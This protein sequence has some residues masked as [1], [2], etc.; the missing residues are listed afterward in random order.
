MFVYSLLNTVL[1]NSQS[2]TFIL[3][4][5]TIVNMMIVQVMI[6][7]NNYAML[8]RIVITYALAVFATDF[9]SGVTSITISL[10][11]PVLVLKHT[12]TVPLFSG[13]T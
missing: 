8:K 3:F 7:A 12:V 9:S 10:A 1:I 6:V 13:T 2:Q 5:S 4:H 11:V